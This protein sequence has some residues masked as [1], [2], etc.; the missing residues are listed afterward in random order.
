MSARGNKFQFIWND[1]WFLWH[2]VSINKG[3]IPWYC[4][5]AYLQIKN[6]NERE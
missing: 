5:K 3:I 6:L 4:D 2:V 1:L